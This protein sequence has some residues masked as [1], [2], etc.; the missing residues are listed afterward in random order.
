MGADL[1][2]ASPA[3]RVLYDTADT[4]LGY[5]ISR[6]CFEGPDEKL[7]QTEYAQPA[8]LATSLACLAAAIEG[9][10]VTSRPAFTAGHSLGEYSALVA[11]G[12]LTFEDGLR[13]IAERARLMAAAGAAT[14]G[15]LAAVIG[16]DE[17]TVEAIC[18]EVD[19]D[20]CNRNLPAQTVIGGPRDVIEKAMALAKERGAQRVV[21]LNVSG[22]FHSRLMTPAVAELKKAVDGTTI[23]APA[24]PVVA[25][26]SAMP[27]QD[28]AAIREELS[29]QIVNP[30]RWHESV[31]YM[32]SAGVTTF[33]EFGPGRVLT[34]M[35]KRIVPGATLV[36]VGSAADAG[37]GDTIPTAG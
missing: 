10:V 4:V 12:A 35:A 7:R 14:P 32:A 1:Y 25:N 9:G 21:E 2:L 37:R 15:T 31:S 28:V 18:R 30:V 11:A 20:V 26:L 8:I 33:M 36:N 17:T 13:L 3:A 24:V 16:L 29:Q 19:A 27:L 22:A 6:L 34:G 23:E 5:E